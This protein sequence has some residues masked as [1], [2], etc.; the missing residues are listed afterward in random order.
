MKEENSTNIEN[1]YEMKKAEMRDAHKK[2]IEFALKHNIDISHW[3][4]LSEESLDEACEQ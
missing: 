4:P 2:A 3:K 1:L